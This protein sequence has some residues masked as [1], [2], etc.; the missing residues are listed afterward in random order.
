[1]QNIKFTMVNLKKKH[2][3]DNSKSNRN[4]DNFKYFQMFFFN[5]TEVIIN[6]T[7]LHVLISVLK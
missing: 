5:I 1:M 2:C 7:D 4:R 6:Q 3:L